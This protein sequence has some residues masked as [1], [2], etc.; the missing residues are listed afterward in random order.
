MNSI[1]KTIRNCVFVAV[2][3]S[4]SMGTADTKPCDAGG[5]S[6]VFV[7]RVLVDRVLVARAEGI[8]F[9]LVPATK[10]PQG[11]WLDNDRRRTPPADLIVLYDFETKLLKSWSAA[12][13]NTS[14]DGLN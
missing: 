7:D 4:A 8:T 6:Q 3:F 1:H 12:A 13:D 5:R 14:Q 2:A 11:V 10:H 9:R